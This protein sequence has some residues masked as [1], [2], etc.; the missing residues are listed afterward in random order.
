MGIDPYNLPEAI[1]TGADRKRGGFKDPEVCGL[2]Q[3]NI[4]HT[5]PTPV[6][7]ILAV[8][9]TLL[10]IGAGGQLWDVARSMIVPCNLVVITG[11]S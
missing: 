8:Y 5:E 10:Y 2:Q 9:I 7:S 6:L 3:N 4:A 1:I 11:D